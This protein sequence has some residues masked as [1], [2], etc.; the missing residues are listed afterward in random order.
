[1]NKPLRFLAMGCMAS[2][3][4]L[5]FTACSSDDNNEPV[6]E[7]DVTISSSTLSDIVSN[8]VDNVVNPTYSDLHAAAVELH[9]ACNDLYAKRKAGS[10]EQSDIDAC[11]TAFK[12]ARRYWE[13]SEAFLYGAATNDELDPHMDSW[14]LDQSQ[15]AEA[16]TSASVI[17]GITGSNPAFFVY[18]NNSHFDSTLGFHGLEFILFRNGANRLA[19]EFNQEY[20]LANGLNTKGD[21]LAQN[22]AKLKT[23][24]NI[25]EAAF[26]A[27]VS[28]DIQNIT[29]LLEYEWDGNADL[30]TYLTDNAPWVLTG[31]SHNGKTS[32]GSTYDAAVTTVGGN[33]SL[34]NSWPLNLQNIFVGGC[35]SIAQ[36]V[37]TQ[38]LGQAYR[39]AT[40]KP[41]A[42]EE[43]TDAADYIESPYSKRS[44]YDYQD[45]IYSIRNSLYGRRGAS[46]DNEHI[47]PD[48]NSLMTFLQNN[49]TTLYNELNTRLNN[50]IS[51]LEKAKKSGTAFIDDPANAQV[52]ECIDAV[53]AL[54][55][56]LNIVGT[57]CARHIS[58]K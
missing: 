43:G 41:Q 45:N 17:A 30:Q 16:L 20:E 5:S 50:A 46:A 12:S 9:T 3:I 19:T 14:P 58:V 47:T 21:N 6:A 33:N 28:A 38:K 1:M 18:E 24:T 11:C 39:V 56:E 25:N 49:N 10:V 13:Q 29:S 15:L 37:Y 23:V 27:A 52:K 40:G 57:W 35:S 26:A 54:D 2:L 7:T 42:G 44:F 55:D 32:T 36:E 53:Q 22:Q 51:T 34:F 48:K 8:Y 4:T 31:S